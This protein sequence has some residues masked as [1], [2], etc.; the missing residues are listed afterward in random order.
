[1]T[2]DR[3]MH[4]ANLG[5]MRR[6][7]SIQQTNKKSFLVNIKIKSRHNYPKKRLINF[8]LGNTFVYNCLSIYL[9]LLRNINLLNLSSIPEEETV[10]IKCDLQPC[11]REAASCVQTCCHGQVSRS[12]C[13]GGRGDA[14]IGRE[15]ARGERDMPAVLVL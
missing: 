13:T 2:K 10:D 8:F 14:V 5:H 7:M 11:V 3:E 9:K 12:C 6:N 1:M 4:T 15:V